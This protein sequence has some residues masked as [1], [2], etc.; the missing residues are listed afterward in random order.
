MIGAVEAQPTTDI[1]P[2]NASGLE[3]IGPCWHMRPI[4]EHVVVDQRHTRE[5]LRPGWTSMQLDQLGAAYRHQR[6]VRQFLDRK[7]PITPLLTSQVP[8]P[9]INP[10]VP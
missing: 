2:I 1:G 3:P 10:P 7:R 9:T 5:R 4:G 6:D 8:D